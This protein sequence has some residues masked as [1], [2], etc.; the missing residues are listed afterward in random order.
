M[1]LLRKSEKGA[2]LPIVVIAGCVFILLGMSMLQL[3]ESER[4]FTHKAV[5]QT[6]A[7]HLAEA[8]V[9]RFV[10]NAY[11]GDVE[12]IDNTSLGEGSY[13][14]DTYFDESPAYVISTGTVGNVQKKVKVEVSFLSPPYEHAIYS[15]NTSGQTW[16]LDLRGLGNPQ[17]TRGGR[18]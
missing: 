13:R 14:V 11:I 5:K 15:C 9:A 12:D 3:A 7:F 8:G 18:G 1:S 10:A 4:V 16:T 6:Q 2:V 17:S